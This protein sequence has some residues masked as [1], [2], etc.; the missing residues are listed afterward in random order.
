MPPSAMKWGVE[1]QNKLSSV[2]E[3]TLKSIWVSAPKE[4][5]GP[6]FSQILKAM[7][8]AGRIEFHTSGD[9]NSVERGLIFGGFSD[10]KKDGKCVTATKPSFQVGAARKF[11]KKK[12]MESKEDKGQSE[13][14][15]VDV[16]AL[17]DDDLAEDD[18]DLED[19]DSLLDREVEK[20]DVTA[21]T[22]VKD[23]NKDCGVGPG[24]KRKACKNCTCGLKEDQ[25]KDPNAAP[26]SACGNCGLGDAFRCSTCP[27]L[28][29]PAFTS[30]DNVVKLVL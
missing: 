10:I 9:V 8:P 13:S 26:K 1:D 5:G 22:N 17:G 12:A 27:Y 20:V 3:N 15:K 14:K 18:V 2:K 16:W 21:P 11:K 29:K 30:K 24:G 23:K 7:A 6:Y 25:E 28:G 4:F 19:E